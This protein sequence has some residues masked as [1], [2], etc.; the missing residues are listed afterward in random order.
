MDRLEDE[1]GL[2]ATCRQARRVESRRGS[3]FFLCGR[4]DADPRY[5]RYPR[6]PVRECGVRAPTPRVAGR[7]GSI[8]SSKRGTERWTAK[9]MPALLRN[10]CSA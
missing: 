9:P 6:L 5:A 8:V 1:V 4:A 7:R 2:C 3:V 10:V